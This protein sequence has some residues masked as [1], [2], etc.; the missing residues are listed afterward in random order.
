M[1]PPF[2]LLQTPKDGDVKAM[3]RSDDDL[4][5]DA[6][7]TPIQDQKSAKPVSL[8]E[9]PIAAFLA[10]SSDDSKVSPKDDSK[11]ARGEP[12]GSSPP[13]PKPMGSAPHSRPVSM[14]YSPRSTPPCSPRTRQ[15]FTGSMGKPASIEPAASTGSSGRTTPVTGNG[16]IT[17]AKRH[18]TENPSPARSITLQGPRAEPAKTLAKTVQMLRRMNSD[19][20][21]EH[22]AER[23]YLD[24][25]TRGVSP[26]LPGGIW[27][28]SYNDF[29]AAARQ[30]PTPTVVGGDW[31]GLGISVSDDEYDD[32]CELDIDEMIRLGASAMGEPQADGDQTLSWL[33]SDDTNPWDRE[34]ST[35]FHSPGR[36]EAASEA[37]TG[38]GATP[39]ERSLKA[40]SVWDD[41]ERYWELGGQASPK[42]TAQSRRSSNARPVPSRTVSS[43]SV[44]AEPFRIPGLSLSTP[45]PAVS[46]DR[47]G[48][49]ASAEAARDSTEA[50][51]KA[52]IGGVEVKKARPERT[53]T[54]RKSAI[55]NF[56]L[57]AHN[58]LPTTETKGE[59]GQ[60]G[61]TSGSNGDAQP[62][63]ESSGEK[64]T[65]RVSWYDEQGFLKMT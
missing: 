26:T 22:R 59:A 63:A 30:P 16:S 5:E 32:D 12:P 56:S 2:P 21:N 36:S 7:S 23:R 53:N 54:L 13:V 17:P 48:D 27:R 50:Q 28:D 44:T 4:F 62:G 31:H 1:G 10:L 46:P 35:L 11:N 38:E 3:E 64:Q 9:D 8:D 60:G 52:A 47:F 24:M 45:T 55:L 61:K 19:V 6:P 18:S 39:S 29:G 14:Q 42:F 20:G 41:G 49:N 34:D 25:G 15:S 37:A 40:V 51:G 43:C 33:D 58:R 57:S 65:A